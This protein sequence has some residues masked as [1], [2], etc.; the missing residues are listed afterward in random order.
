VR[1]PPEAVLL[2][3]LSSLWVLAPATQA[4]PVV[5]GFEDAPV[6]E[7]PDDLFVIDGSFSVVAAGEGRAVEIAAVPLAESGAIFGE[8]M[9]GA[10]SVQATVVAEAKRRS[11]PRFGVGLHGLSGYRLRVVPASNQIELVKNEETV[12]AA[13]FTWTPGQPLTLRLDITAA[14]DGKW[15]VEGRAWPATGERPAEPQIALDAE[16]KPGTGKASIWGTPYAGLPIQFDDLHSEPAAT[17]AAD[18]PADTPEN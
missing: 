8:S 13:P 16:G 6:G 18:P 2:A 4:A 5:L 11:T 7:E 10:G 17:P 3:A 9:Q 14:G 12:L 1:R 15:R